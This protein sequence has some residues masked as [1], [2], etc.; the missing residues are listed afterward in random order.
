MGTDGTLSVRLR[1]T[2]GGNGCGRSTAVY[3]ATN[4]MKV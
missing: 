1:F 4:I 2:V 3:V